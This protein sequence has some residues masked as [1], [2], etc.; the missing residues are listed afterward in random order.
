MS[1]ASPRGQIPFRWVLSR[2]G[3]CLIGWAPLPFR[4]GGAPRRC[5][6]VWWMSW[7]QYRGEQRRSRKV[8]GTA[9]ARYRW[10]SEQ[11]CCPMAWDRAHALWPRGSHRW[12]LRSTKPFRLAT[13][14]THIAPRMEQEKRRR[15]R[16]ARRRITTVRYAY[17]E[18]Y[19]MDVEI[20][21][22]KK[23]SYYLIWRRVKRL[24]V[25]GLNE[26]ARMTMSRK[27]GK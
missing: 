24:T 19:E 12:E 3:G 27:K 14:D 25:H 1:V 10:A 23:G 6:R 4:S 16:R 15:N 20:K 17:C 13:D 21:R 9:H 7:I 11:H 5:R 26:C 2:L 8:V 18:E 22:K